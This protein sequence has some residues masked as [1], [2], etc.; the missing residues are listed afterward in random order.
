VLCN[1]FKHHVRCEEEHLFPD[2]ERGLDGRELESLGRDI[3]RL[4]RDLLDDGASWEE[5]RRG[6][7][8][9]QLLPL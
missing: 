5:R 3:A 2:A 7:L 9:L 6:G 8:G 1:L 4:H